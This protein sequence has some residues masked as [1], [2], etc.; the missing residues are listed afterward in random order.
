MNASGIRMAAI[1]LMVAGVLGLVYG[2]FTYTRS[3]SHTELGPISINVKDQRHV[4]VPIWV[5]VIGV[6]L[7]GALLL[8]QGRKS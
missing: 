4:N 5:G 2:G 8:T 3:E 7:G 1:I 6:A